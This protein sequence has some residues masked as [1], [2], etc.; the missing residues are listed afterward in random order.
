MGL[1]DEKFTAITKVR[2]IL[3]QNPTIQEFVGD[4][5]FPLTAPSEFGGKDVEGDII[6]YQRDGYKREDNKMGVTL[7]RSI[8]YMIAISDNYDRSLALAK[9]IYEALDGEHSA[10]DFRIKLEDYTEEYVNQKFF[11]LLQFSI[12]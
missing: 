12:E 3:L 2:A 10:E 8:F 1:A 7:Q 9:A 6:V 4:K 5:I 11:Q